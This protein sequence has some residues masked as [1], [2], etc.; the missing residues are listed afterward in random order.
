M[1][2][3][4]C[5][6]FHWIVP[7]NGPQGQRG[8]CKW[9]S[10]KVFWVLLSMGIESVPS[11]GIQILGSTVCT[12]LLLGPLGEVGQLWMVPSPFLLG[13]DNLCR[14]LIIRETASLAIKG[15][16]LAE[17]TW[18]GCGGGK[19]NPSVPGFKTPNHNGGPLFRSI[20]SGQ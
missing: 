1:A 18:K 15:M 20:C 11:T 5:S 13:D 19:N 16:E 7:Q 10:G 8:L 9:H 6:V 12:Q 2:P 3:P 17:G 14:T 4:N